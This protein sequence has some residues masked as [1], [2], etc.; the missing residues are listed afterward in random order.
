MEVL[1]SVSWET[2]TAAAKYQSISR[3]INRSI[4]HPHN[5][6]GAMANPVLDGLWNVAINC[7]QFSSIEW[8]LVHHQSTATVC[9]FVW[10]SAFCCSVVFVPPLLS[11]LKAA[12]P[13]SV[14]FAPWT[15]L[16]SDNIFRDRHFKLADKYSNKRPRYDRHENCATVRK[17]IAAILEKKQKKTGLSITV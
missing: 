14:Y 15:D 12:L 8:I 1:S 5:T 9:I 11:S 7:N 2:L 3:S 4:N 13:Q 6:N 10:T 17:C 16:M